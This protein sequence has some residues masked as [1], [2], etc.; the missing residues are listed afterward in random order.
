VR[1]VQ[2]YAEGYVTQFKAD[3]VSQIVAPGPRKS[4]LLVSRVQRQT[5]GHGL[6]EPAKIDAVHSVLVQLRQQDSRELY[7]EDRLV[8]R[9]SFRAQT[10]SVVNHWRRPRANL[11]SAFDTIIFTVPQAALNEAAEDQG[12]RPVETL[13][14]EN[15]GRLDQTIWSLSQSLLP[16]LERPKEVGSM[17]AERVLLATTTYFAHVFGGMAPPEGDRHRLSSAQIARVTD[18]MLGQFNSDISLSQL[19]FETDLSP[20]RFSRAFRRSMGESPDRWLRRQRIE[21][22]K[23]L[24]RETGMSLSQIAMICGFNNSAHFARAFASSVGV[25]PRAWRAQIRN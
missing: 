10:V 24:L 14:C 4:R 23:R 21:R 12:V 9:G 20:R 2:R 19:A 18:L 17:Y 1:S 6:A 15:E 13:S 7:L 25:A 5:P 3:A 8:F 16:A 22:A 11:L